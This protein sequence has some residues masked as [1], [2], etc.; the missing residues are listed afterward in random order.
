MM[1][2]HKQV[3]LTMCTG[4]RNPNKCYAHYEIYIYNKSTILQCNHHASGFE[5][6]SSAVA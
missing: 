3:K 4:E 1:S 6:V 2:M 5:G